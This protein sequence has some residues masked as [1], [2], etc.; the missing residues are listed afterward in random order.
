MRIMMPWVGFFA[1]ITLVIALDLGVFHRKAHVVSFKESLSWSFVWIGLALSFNLY[2]F[3]A[4]GPQAGMEFLTGYVVEKSLS[5]D[6]V[7][8]FMTIFRSFNVPLLYQHRV[9]FWGIIGVMMLRALFIALG[10]ALIAQF[11]WVFYLFGGFL[12]YTAYKFMRHEHHESTITDHPLLVWVFKR[13][14]FTKDYDGQKFFTNR[15]GKWMATP[16]FFALISIEF[17]DV[18]FAIDSIPA[19]FAITQDPYIIFTSNIFAI[20]GLRSLYFIVANLATRFTY[21]SYGLAVIL[22]FIGVKMILHH[23]YHFPAVVSLGV[24]LGTLFL[25][26]VASLM[27]EQRQS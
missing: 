9:L 18:I 1:L 5:L 22:G 20:L 12:L 8:I 3:Y 2:L 4:R 16:L 25:S 11:S 15:S 19:I 24:I 17:A 14:R 27:K 6:N 23:V 26:I 10:A 13:F 7:F 21:L